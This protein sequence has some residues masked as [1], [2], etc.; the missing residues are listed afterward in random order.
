MLTLYPSFSPL[1]LPLSCARPSSSPCLPP[2][3][4]IDNEGLGL[5]DVIFKTIQDMDIDYRMG[6]SK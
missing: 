5:P 3:S 1:I 2:Q 4:L 6:V